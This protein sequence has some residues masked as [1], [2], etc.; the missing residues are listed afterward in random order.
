[1]DNPVNDEKKQI[2]INFTCFSLAALS[3]AGVKTDTS[4]GTT[5]VLFQ[6]HTHKSNLH[7]QL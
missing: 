1:M 7:H 4:T 2:S 3:S 5:T 6:G